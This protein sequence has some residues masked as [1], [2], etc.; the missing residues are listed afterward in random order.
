VTVGCVVVVVD[1]GATVVEA[2]IVVDV[3]VVGT[4]RGSV[5]DVVGGG[6][7]GGGAVVVVVDVDVV[8][9]DVDVV[10]LLVVVVVVGGASVPHANQWLMA[11]S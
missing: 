5:V 8:L 1:V 3:V 10:V 9:V 7:G 4:S 2:P 11:G 6:G